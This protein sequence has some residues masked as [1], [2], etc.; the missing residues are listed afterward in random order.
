[1]SLNWL[2]GRSING[3]SFNGAFLAV[4]LGMESLLNIKKLYFRLSRKIHTY[5]F[6]TLFFI[7]ILFLGG[8]LSY[9][10]YL[11][12]VPLCAAG[13]ISLTIYAIY[14]VFP[15]RNLFDDNK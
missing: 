7:G 15:E 2:K 12:Y 14:I 1:M 3:I 5:V 13:F 9:L 8:I 10:L 4:L 11:L 6:D